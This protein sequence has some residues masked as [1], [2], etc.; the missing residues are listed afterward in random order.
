MMYISWLVPWGFLGAVA[1]F[2]AVAPPLRDPSRTMWR[3][4]AAV[5]GGCKNPMASASLKTPKVIFLK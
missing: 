2:L 1:W 5:G 3:P 4:L